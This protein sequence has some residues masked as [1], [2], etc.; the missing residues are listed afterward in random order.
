MWK[1]HVILIDYLKFCVKAAQQKKFFF[2]WVDVFFSAYSVWVSKKT[3]K[4][5]FYFCSWFHCCSIVYVCLW[6][7]VCVKVCVREREKEGE[8]KASFLDSNFERESK[9]SFSDGNLNKLM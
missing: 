7:S 5:M 8:S 3:I 1:K 2:I 6:E 4:Q 9:A